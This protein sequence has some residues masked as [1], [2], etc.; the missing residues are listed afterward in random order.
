MSTSNFSQFILTTLVFISLG[1]TVLLAHPQ[2][3]GQK[4]YEWRDGNRS[5]PVR[6][7]VWYPTNDIDESGK[8]NTQLPFDLPPTIR[9]ATPSK[10]TFPVVVLSH[11]TG[12][13]RYGLAWLAISL[14]EQ[15]YIVAAP[16]HWGNT[17]DNK[18]PEYFVRYWERPLDISFVIDRLLEDEAIGTLIDR[19][20]IGVAGFS[21]GGFTALAL[22]GAVIDCDLLLENAKNKKYQKEMKVP[23]LGDLRKLTDRLDCE[24]G[25]SQ[26]KD[27]RIKA[28][29]AMAPALGLAF[30]NPQQVQQIDIPVFIVGIEND[31]I[32]PIATNA[33]HYHA[34]I[35][36]S[37]YF[38]ISGKAGHYV[39]LNEGNEGL[40]KEAKRYYMDHTSIDR[41]E[42][43]RLVTDQV[44][45]FLKLN[46]N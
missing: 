26:L 34:L 13:N 10:G 9:N 16:D 22:A 40:K 39:M 17:F 32:T 25:Q 8:R 36:Y 35:Q 43:H 5:R 11:G 28:A 45:E 23:E 30:D 38:E 21:L 14:V 27:P 12:G 18:V 46:L 33:H 41:K 1:T 3:V 44:I 24:A 20:R 29:V 31:V 7:E 42:V 6:T 19:K 15:G 2:Q 4:T 37:I